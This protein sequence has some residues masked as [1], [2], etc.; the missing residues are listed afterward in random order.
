M[1][2]AVYTQ[3][4]PPEVFRRQDG[5]KPVPRDND[6]LIRIAV[7]TATPADCAMRK[8]DPFI[9][10][11]FTG[12]MRPKK[13]IMGVEF[14]GQIEAVGSQVTRFKV[15]D[16]VMGATCTGFG[17][18]AEY[19]RLPQDGILYPKPD[20]LT[21]AEAVT[22]CDGGL[23]ALPFLRDNG[24]IQNGHS[25]LI[26]GA[27][28]SV[29]LAA[30]QLAKYYEAEVTAVC[31]EKNVAY[32]KK[33]GA[34]HVI[35]YTKEDFTQSGR[36]YDIVFDAIGKSSYSRC[37]GILKTHGKYLTTVPSFGILYH[38][39]STALFGKRKAIFAA[40]GLNKPPDKRNDLA[41]LCKLAEAGVIK[42]VY[43]RIY[44]L[45]QIVDA[46]KYVETERKRGTVVISV[47][48]L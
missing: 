27:S 3:Y 33:Y 17:A 23:T 42:P 43:D 31:S 37:K 5:A 41:I 34:D 18:Y 28:G 40:T 10:R 39:L 1:K 11:F 13:T 12:L 26:N 35:D 6:V 21:F 19:L 14:S 32:V 16:K 24:K 48:N 8:A 4:G 45:D 25:V 20:S 36:T 2:A 46:H 22:F 30:M 9:A 7:T 44:P 29:G 47:S 38:M 15:G